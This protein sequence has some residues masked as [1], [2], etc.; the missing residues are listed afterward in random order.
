MLTTVATDKAPANLQEEAKV[1]FQEIAFAYAV[2]SDPTRRKRYDVTGSTSESID[3][4]DFS[5]SEF[6]QEQFR[7][8]VTADAIETFSK[9]YKDSPEE[10][11]AIL[12]AYRKSKGK[13]G[14][15]YETVMLSNP[16]EDEDRFRLIIDEAI[17]NGEVEAYKA[18]TD[19]TPR[20]KQA[21]MK[22]ARAEGE[23]AMAY[24]KELGVEEKLFGKGKGRKKESSEDALSALIKKNQAGRSSF[25]DKLEAKYAGN[26]NGTKGKKGKKRNLQAEEAEEA[27]EDGMP[28]EEAFQKAAAK[29]KS[30]GK[31]KK[32]AAGDEADG[33][34]SEEAFQKAA[35]K[36]K[37]KKAAAG[38]EASNGQKAKRQKR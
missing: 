8:V 17:A 38:D 11:D 31:G 7:D 20:A 35:A 2:L 24:A 33:M 27:E 6:Y 28:S 37:G 5:W 21:R 3:F 18:Y 26:G 25:L 14:A 22:A 19:E 15:I 10:K 32:A 34:P 23:E 36:L 4:D 12:Q 16:L 9:G 13:W 29:L 1:K 30:K